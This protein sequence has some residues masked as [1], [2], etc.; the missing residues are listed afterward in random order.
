MFQ[1]K[2]YNIKDFD[3]IHSSNFNYIIDDNTK[4]TIIEIASLL[5]KKI[6]I[7]DLTLPKYK[8]T[9]NNISNNTS[10][11][12]LRKKKYLNNNIP[13]NENSSILF[14]KTEVPSKKNDF[15]IKLNEIRSN[16]NKLT[17]K[18]YNDISKK[19]IN[20]ID[21][22]V[23]F[24]NNDSLNKIEN[25]L[26]NDIEN[27]IENKEKMNKIGKFI[28]EI[29]STNAFY[30]KIYAN[31][32]S[33]LINKYEIMKN[34]FDKNLKEYYNIFENIEYVDSVKEYDKFCEITKI[35]EKR[36]ALSSFLLNLT[37]NNI[38]SKDHLFNIIIKLMTNIL[39][40]INI[41]NKINEVNE[42]TENIYILFNM[43]FFIDY[44]KVKNDLLFFNNTKSFFD[45]IHI[46]ANSKTNMYPS[47]STKTKFKFM[48]ILGL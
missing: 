20:N 7:N 38:I 27:D 26:E 15:D 17:D 8:N 44:H 31:L 4:L 11:N 47:F 34:V 43:E 9:S 3:I 6:N 37:I 18:N 41:P 29:A 42:I 33:E 36:K 23:I 40:F 46:L 16:L 19:I 13:N 24:L 48:N 2:K 45:T 35:N 14:K 25:N 22:F 28:F 10:N 39:D 30:S 12:S 5:G 21:D 32:Y 1:Y